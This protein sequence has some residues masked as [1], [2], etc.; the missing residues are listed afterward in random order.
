MNSSVHHKATAPEDTN[1]TQKD[2]HI[3][4]LGRMWTAESR[5]QTVHSTKLS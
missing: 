2:K 1:K 5:V 4:V 3:Q